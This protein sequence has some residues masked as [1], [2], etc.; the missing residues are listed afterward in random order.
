MLNYCIVALF[1]HAAQFCGIM[2]EIFM[3]IASHF[4]YFHTFSHPFYGTHALPSR[5]IFRI[6]QRDS[7][8]LSNRTTEVLPSHRTISS[9]SGDE[10]STLWAIVLRK[11]CPPIAPYLPYPVT[12]FQRFGQSYYGSFAHITVLF[13]RIFIRFCIITTELRKIMRYRSICSTKDTNI[14]TGCITPC[15]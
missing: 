11:F 3:P 9:V 13:F 2:T 5:H 14:K 1:R 10:F 6:Y 4:P 15:L 7:N 12:S 8:A